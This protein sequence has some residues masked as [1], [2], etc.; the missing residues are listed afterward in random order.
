M[1]SWL[2]AKNN[3]SSVLAEAM[4][5]EQTSLVVKSGEGDRF[6]SV[7]PFRITVDNE[8]MECTNRVDDVLTITRGVE[9]TTAAAHVI[10]KSVR[11]NIT[12]SIITQ[13]QTEADSKIPKSLVAAKGDIVVAAGENTPARLPPGGDGQMLRARPSESY[14]LQWEDFPTG[15]AVITSGTYTGNNTANRA[16][17]HGLGSVPKIVFI[18]NQTDTSY[19]Y[20]FVIFPGFGYILGFKLNSGSWISSTGSSALAVYQMTSTYFYIGNSSDYPN[21]ANHVNKLYRWVAFA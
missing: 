19:L 15:G 4:D 2:R 9:D 11:L 3:A 17:A 20:F 14:G 7:F 8:I 16:I 18:Q 13:L 5:A 12:A 1:T 21:T 6:P 10:N